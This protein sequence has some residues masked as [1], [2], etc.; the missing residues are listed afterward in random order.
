MSAISWTEALPSSTSTGGDVEKD[1]L[2]MMTSIALGFGPSFVWPGSGGGSAA[3][4]GEA[5]L[6]QARSAVSTSGQ[7]G[8]YGDGFL[9]LNPLHG[10]LHH[11]GSTST[12]LV[13]H[14][15]MVDHGSASSLSAYWLIQSGSFFTSSVSTG[16]ISLSFP[17]PYGAIPIVQLGMYSVSG[18][19]INYIVNLSSITT[20]GFSAALSSLNTGGPFVPI[21]NSLVT[22]FW[23]SS[24]TVPR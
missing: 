12:G 24:G 21:S 8:G 6:G 15:N 1:F 23:E 2:S 22:V 10:S 7:T 14:A 9:L 5:A 18:S 13:G 16:S 11:I 20:A 17:T 3:S 4:A 19:P